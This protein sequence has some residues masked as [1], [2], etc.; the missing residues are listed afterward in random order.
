MGKNRF[1]F[2]LNSF[3]SFY[4]C[5]RFY[6]GFSDISGFLRPTEDKSSKI[7]QVFMFNKKKSYSLANF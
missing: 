6:L 5:K 7:I 2:E 4:S 3:D 1:N